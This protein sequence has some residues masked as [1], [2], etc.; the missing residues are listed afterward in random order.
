[1]TTGDRIKKIR[2]ERH[3]TQQDFSIHINVK[4][5]T[6]A[7]Y[8][9]DK[10]S[11]SSA[12]IS[13]ICREFNVNETWLRTGEGEM[14]AR[15][16]G[17][18][19]QVAEWVNS[20]FTHGSDTEKSFVTAMS[21]FTKEDWSTLERLIRKVWEEQQ[22]LAPAKTNPP[23]LTIDEKVALYRAELEAEEK[24]KEKSSALH[25]TGEESA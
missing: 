7:L 9:A 1:M 25:G 16:S 11:P 3:L 17:K 21:T 19:E 10:I 23:A 18:A 5:N 4:R 2:Q 6:V 8:E 22:A 13:L 12:V 15:P 24:A 20:I 14:F